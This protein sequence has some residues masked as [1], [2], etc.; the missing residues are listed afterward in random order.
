[1]THL[2]DE[3]RHAWRRLRRALGF[4]ITTLI[5][6]ALGLGATTAM[7]SIVNG[8]VLRPLP[9]D[10]SERLVQI[11]HSLKVSGVSQVEESD[12]TFLLYQRHN[13]VFEKI[14]LYA[15]SNLNLSPAAGATTDAMRLTAAQVSADLFAV[16]RVSPA[17]GRGFLDGE[18]RPTSRRVVI[19]SDGLWRRTFGAD[20]GIV[21]KRLVLDGQEREVVGVMPA[22]F[23]F[24]SASTQL[25][26]PLRLDPAHTSALS[27]NFTAIGRL[28]PG[29]TIESATA[30]L[31]RILPRL[32]DEYP[33][34]VPR[35]VFEQAQVRPMIRPLRDVIVGDVSRLLWILFG[36]VGLLLVIACA[37][38]ANLFLVRAEGR[39]RELAI[40]NALGAG[41]TALLWQYLSEA[42]LLAIS[43]GVIGVGLAIAGIRLLVTL[44]HG[45]DLPRLTEVNVDGTVFLFALGAIAACA[46]AVSVVPVL[47]TRRIPIASVLKDAGRSATTGSE[48]HR[49][50]S[51]LVIAQVA[52]ALVLVAASGLMARS[53]ARLRDV[54]PGFNPDSLLTLNVALPEAK[55]PTAVATSQFYDRLIGGV[56]ALPGVRDVA[57]TTWLPLGTTGETSALWV[58]EPAPPPNAV[59]P[60]HQFVYST[61]NYHSAMGIPILS[62]RGLA[63]QDPTRPLLEALVSRSFAE[64]Y[65]KNGTA[66]GRRVRPGLSGSWFTIVG[67]VGDVHLIALDRPAEQAVYFPL[68]LPDGDSTTVMNNVTVV[69]RTSGSP[70]AVTAPVRQIVRSLDP[71]LPV[72]GERLMSAILEASTAR[73]RFLMFLLGLASTLALVLGAVGLYGVM[74]YGVSLRQ[75]EIGVRMAL[76]ARPADV[77][78]MISRQGVTIA[79]VGVVAGL[80]ASIGVTRFLRGLLYD[81]SPTDPLT[82]GVTCVVLLAVAFISCWL[83]ARRAAAVDPTVA[84]RSD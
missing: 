10:Q 25:W 72:Y 62:G 80:G 84:L 19:L 33:V 38:V 82:L 15:A 29:V 77:S 6:L 11:S 74:A 1:M 66:L 79:A 34:N 27:F 65:W 70:D 28:K 44:P 76:G 9:Y 47:R 63:A 21:G 55:Y 50:R 52:L 3:T 12:G 36:A 45:I 81:I 49:V 2:L 75:R 43:G 5:V 40:R 42:L 35:A 48:R 73:T 60:V 54:R 57:L 18:D 71:A 7:F 4:T 37:N 16:L 69:V 78:Q 32:L 46:V 39:Q 13:R 20:P 8:I 14:G 22:S 23:R 41:R 59:P 56:R 26:V 68:V 58:D 51:M 67:V 53:F 61:S 31:A 64:R 24:P 30:D 83:P 17:R